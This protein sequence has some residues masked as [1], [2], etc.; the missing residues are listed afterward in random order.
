MNGKEMHNLLVETETPEIKLIAVNTVD[1]ENFEVLYQKLEKEYFYL[2][3]LVKTRTFQLDSLHT[4]QY[5]PDEMK[6]LLKVIKFELQ[7]GNFV[8]LT[9]PYFNLLKDLHDVLL[10]T[11]IYFDY[12]RYT[13]NQECFLSVAD[14]EP[15]IKVISRT[16]SRKVRRLIS[17]GFVGVKVFDKLEELII[18][19]LGTCLMELYEDRLLAISITDEPQKPYC[20]TAPTCPIMFNLKN[21]SYFITLSD[22]KRYAL[23]KQIPSVANGLPHIKDKEHP[24][25]DLSYNHYGVAATYFDWE[26]GKIISRQFR[27]IEGELISL[28][29]CYD[30]LGKAREDEVVETD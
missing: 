28:K 3:R 25:S 16:S 18:T 5:D 15:M 29:A 14:S 10:D 9:L 8:K 13:T 27:L 7:V 17:R 6:Q 4:I 19:P 24:C 26:T 21:Q 12:R 1:D 23:Y 2:F 20:L 22:T 11:S 30:V